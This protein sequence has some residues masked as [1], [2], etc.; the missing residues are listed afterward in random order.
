MTSFYYPTEPG[1]IEKMRDEWINSCLPCCSFSFLDFYPSTLPENKPFWMYLYYTKTQTTDQ[2][3]H[4]LQ[5]KVQFR[6]L[7]LEHGREEFTDQKNVHVY[8]FGGGTPKIWFKC[9]RIEE[10]RGI[11][12]KFLT[13]EDFNHAEGKELLSAIR[14]SIAPVKRLNPIMIMQRTFMEIQD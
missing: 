7:V 11:D 9:S 14:N 3:Y 8:H 2:K 10:I 5:M 6:V 13:N 1:W 4:H 12:R